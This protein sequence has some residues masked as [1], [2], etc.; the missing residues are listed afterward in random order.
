MNGKE[1]SMNGLGF[2]AC[3]HLFSFGCSGEVANLVRVGERYGVLVELARTRIETICR[4]C[5]NSSHRGKE[6]K[7]GKRK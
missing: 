5:R 2:A 4:Q 6:K 7:E 1:G 3:N